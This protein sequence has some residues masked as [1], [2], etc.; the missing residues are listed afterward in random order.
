MAIA[1]A[2]TPGDYASAKAKFDRIESDSLP[3]GA[4]IRLTPAE[5]NAWVQQQVP[6]VTDGVRNPRLDLIAPGRVR[7]SAVVDFVKLRSSQGEPPGWFLTKLLEGEHPVSVTARIRSENGEATVDVERVEISGIAIDGPALDFLIRN[8][9]LALYPDAVVGRPFPLSHHIDR[10]DIQ[11][12][13]ATAII[14]R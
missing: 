5:L 1:C 8:F 6:A 3:A 7:G 9:L 12:E 13:G 10:L 11:P 14:G 4:R 2:A